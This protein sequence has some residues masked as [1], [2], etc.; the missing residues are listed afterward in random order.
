M[1]SSLNTTELSALI[2]VSRTVN[3]HLD[4]DD[5]LESVM[6][7]TT[8]VMQVEASSLVLVDDDTGDLLFHV[9]RGEHAQAVKPIRMKRGEG[10]VGWVVETGKSVIVNDVTKDERFCGKV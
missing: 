6:S 9:A 8:E 7:V 5:V 2:E 3:A 4:L 10:V 1:A